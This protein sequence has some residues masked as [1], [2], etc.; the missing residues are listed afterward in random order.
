[1]KTSE[2]TPE[3]IEHVKEIYKVEKSI[4]KTKDRLN[5][6]LGIDLTYHN[7]RDIIK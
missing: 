4:R 6:T 3:I 7:I 1:M 5:E 2:I